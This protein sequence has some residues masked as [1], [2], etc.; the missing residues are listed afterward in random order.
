MN[1]NN[2]N[3]IN[4]NNSHPPWAAYNMWQNSALDPGF[5]LNVGGSFASVGGP[6]FQNTATQ[7]NYSMNANHF[8]PIGGP[9]FHTAAQQPMP[10]NYSMNAN[11]HPVPNPLPHYGAHMTATAA[12]SSVWQVPPPPPQAYLPAAFLPAAASNSYDDDDDDNVSTEMTWDHP[13]KKVGGKR[14]SVEEGGS[15]KRA[16]I[17]SYKKPRVLVQLEALYLIERIQNVELVSI[18][19]V[20]D[21][22]PQLVK[23]MKDFLQRPGMTKSNLCS[24]LGSINSGSLNKFLMSKGQDQCGNVSYRQGWIFFEKLRILE[25]RPKSDARLR[26]ELAHPNGFSLKKARPIRRV[27]WLPHPAFFGW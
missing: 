5:N 6:S 23:K 2:P 8:A 15:S 7:Q 17:D 18:W 10:V 3:N 12:F 27:P 16:K 20:Y 19:P 1:P 4:D 9:S 25:G 22:C 11:N 14:K 13:Q 24:A 26:N 21:S